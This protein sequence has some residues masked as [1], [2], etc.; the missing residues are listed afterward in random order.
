MGTLSAGLPDAL[1]LTWCVGLPG[2]VLAGAG[3]LWEGESTGPSPTCCL[4]LLGWR[5]G[6]LTTSTLPVGSLP[7]LSWA[8]LKISSAGGFFYQWWAARR[9]H[10]VL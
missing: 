10:L 8:R 2:A 6:S 7:L 3:L 5:V 4:R 9:G 1:R